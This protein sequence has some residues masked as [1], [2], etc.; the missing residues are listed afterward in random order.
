MP[1]IAEILDMNPRP[2]VA[3]ILGRMT[4]EAR[5]ELS[6]LLREDVLISRAEKCLAAAKGD[7]VLAAELFTEFNLEDILNGLG[8]RMLHEFP[9]FSP[10]ELGQS[11][12]LVARM[13]CQEAA[14]A[15]R[16]S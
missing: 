12:V 1:T 15:R 7:P 10:A 9:E 8:E 2:T 5:K 3:E 13:L 11:L 4:S 6:Q 14:D 16:T